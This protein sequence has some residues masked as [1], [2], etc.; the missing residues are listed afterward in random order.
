MKRGFIFLI[1]FSFTLVLHAIPYDSGWREFKQ[2]N[3]VTF[4]ARA[5][6][7]EFAGW[8]ETQDGYRIVPGAD[9]YYYYAIL[10]ANGDFVPSNSKVGLDT[11]IAES[12]QLQLGAAK[13]NEIDAR[14]ADYRRELEQN[15]GWFRQKREAANGGEVTLRVGVILVDF[16]PSRKHTDDSD[17]PY[18]YKK[19]SFDKILFSRDYWYGEFG[20]EK[21]PDGKAIYGSMR[22]YYNQQSQG[23]LDIVGKDGLPV[24]LNPIDPAYPG[25]E[26]PQWIVLPESFEYYNGSA[27]GWSSFL[28]DA[29]NVFEVTFP[30]I[31]LDEYENLF[32]IYGGSWGFGGLWP[33]NILNMS[34]IGEQYFGPENENFLCNIGVYCHEFAHQLGA[35][36][37]YEGESNIDSWF[38]S[39]MSSGSYNGNETEPDFFVTPLDLSCPAGLSPFYKLLWEWSEPIY[40]NEMIY[41]DFEVNY[42]YDNPNYYVINI[43]GKREYFV[44]EN[45]LKTGFDYY[46]PVDPDYDP[47]NPEEDPNGNEGGLLIWYIDPDT[48]QDSEG[49]VCANNIY[50]DYPAAIMVGHSFPFIQGDPIGS[51]QNLTAH[52]TPS[53]K[54]R[55]GS[56][57]SGI[58]IENIRWIPGEQKTVVNITHDYGDNIVIA[59]DETWG[60]LTFNKNVYILNDRSI[61]INSGAEI[62]FENGKSLTIMPGASISIQGSKKRP[63]V[64]QYEG[65]ND[66]SEGI[67][68]MDDVSELVLDNLFIRNAF[69]AISAD[70]SENL[71]ITGV[72]FENC[73]HP[74]KDITDRNM[75]EFNRCHFIETDF[76]GLHTDPVEIK[77]RIVNST[78][79]NSHLGLIANYRLTFEN[80]I[81]Y[82]STIN[83]L[84]G[85]KNSVFYETEFS[86]VTLD[87][88][89]DYN[90][91]YNSA[92]EIPD[93]PGNFEADPE[94]VDAASGDFRL[95]PTSPC[96]DAG[97]PDSDYS[98][99]P[100]P[101]GGRINIGA[102]GNTAFA[103][104]SF[105]NFLSTD[106]TENTIIS[107]NTLLLADV[108]IKDGVSLQIDPGA[109]IGMANEKNLVVNGRIQAIGEPGNPIRFTSLRNGE[110]WKS[111]YLDRAK[112]GNTFSYTEISGSDYGIYAEG[113]TLSVNHSKFFENGTSGLLLDD[114]EADITSSTFTDNKLYGI[115]ITAGNTSLTQNT[116]KDNGDKGVYLQ[117]LSKCLITDNTIENNGYSGKSKHTAGVFC[118]AASPVLKS[119]RIR[120]NAGNGLFLMSYSEPVLNFDKEG[121][122]QI[123]DNGQGF[124]DE[125]CAEIFDFDNVLPHLDLGLN[126][127]YDSEGNWFIA[128]GKQSPAPISVRNNYWGTT[129]A[130]EI[131]AALNGNFEFEP[132]STE[133]NAEP[134]IEFKTKEKLFQ[135][136][137]AKEISGDEESAVEKYDLLKDQSTGTDYSK[138]A[139]LRKFGI[140]VGKTENSQS[141]NALLISQ[142]ENPVTKDLAD[143]LLGLKAVLD[144][145]PGNAYALFDSIEQNPQDLPD[146]VFAAYDKELVEKKQTNQSLGK[147]AGLATIVADK[148]EKTD[149]YISNTEAHLSKLFKNNIPV[150]EEIQLPNRITLY[151]NYPNPFNPETTIKFYLPERTKLHLA[152]YNVLGQRIRVLQNG[153]LEQGY[154]H[155]Q[156]S[157]R[158]AQG[159]TVASGMYFYVLKTD[160]SVLSR[161]MLL[162]K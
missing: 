159:Q 78:L 111:I 58:S 67:V 28:S 60:D 69:H 63:V 96:I 135:E 130:R 146:S 37:E 155:L 76:S 49:I 25:A 21:H 145:N 81:F 126:D 124:S 46:T 137:L 24:I 79:S 31:D 33:K 93:N 54:L 74:V 10:S 86:T 27:G 118:Y 136:A 59:E 92:L 129:V 115:Y 99:E 4:T 162:L 12:Y 2:P 107:S 29:R 123:I 91:F 20:N 51:G 50:S 30:G 154:Q 44:L 112:E 160:N 95:L 13:Q 87:G 53:S 101:N 8:V 125:R 85:G 98:L 40:L 66:L 142:N 158:N 151:Q 105:S 114:S 121:R 144:G 108:V 94:F 147:S 55:D 48:Y 133:S 83:C 143:Q 22:D 73:T 17:Y 153:A 131:D 70:Q 14:K 149:I 65:Q 77:I 150:E 56:T 148:I 52:T 18:G 75:L 32:F 103:T 109:Y 113:S 140:Q 82:S 104:R 43:L 90:C 62:K 134:G 45:R 68:F 61:T 161:K 72:T 64:F 39:L 119:N 100:M 34:I 110:P 23:K 84:I 38:W 88:G 5:W 106:I 80:S 9:G 47:A 57:E 141:L 97:D 156:W 35:S 120:Y 1:F 16:T 41:E 102:Y 7:D 42:N 15:A 89:S 117:Y 19:E 36:D 3:G 71:K 157:G 139:L 26:V 128:T 127:I 11:P 6:G 132:F 122:N 116:I 138:S 152:I